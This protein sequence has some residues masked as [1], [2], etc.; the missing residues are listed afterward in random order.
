MHDGDTFTHNGNRFRVS[1]PFDD[2]QDAPWEREDGHGPV[3]EA[4]RR[5]NRYGYISKA[6]GQRFL[7]E[8]WLYD[9]AEACRIARRDGWGV[10]AYKLHTERGA[11]GFVRV[12]GHW[13]EGRRLL[14]FRSKWHDDINDAI[15]EA[16]AAHRATFPSAKAYAAR[17][18]EADFK[19]LDDWCN[20]R[21]CYVGC[22][23]TLLDDDG[24]ATDFTASLWGVESD[25]GEYLAEVARELADEIVS[26][27]KAAACV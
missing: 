24:D 3:T 19:R 9:F 6:P 26:E 5:A 13:F 11:N 10:P 25:G 23:V 12:T 16:Y 17:A 2:T 14:D 4:P 27:I 7:G 15:S 22:V 8:H 20:D 1:F 18:A 21:W